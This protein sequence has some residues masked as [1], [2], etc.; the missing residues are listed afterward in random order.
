VLQGRTESQIPKTVTLEVNEH[1]AEKL[2]V[3]GQLGK[4]ELAITGLASPTST[5]TAVG[6]VEATWASD[7]SPALLTM[8]ARASS[9]A[10]PEAKTVKPPSRD[11]IVIMR[12]SKVEP[13]VEQ[14]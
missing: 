14:H 1:D 5:E 4:V 11:G 12:G 8:G 13:K 6:T 9:V 3:A 7:V 10:T 2:L